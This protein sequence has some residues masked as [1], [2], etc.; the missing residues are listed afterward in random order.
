MPCTLGSATGD[1][2]QRVEAKQQTSEFAAAA[3]TALE[4]ITATIK[5]VELLD[6]PD[7]TT[8]RT[9][10]DWAERQASAMDLLLGATPPHQYMDDDLD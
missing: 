2:A 7:L 5:L 10:R 1:T 3:T 8:V 4:R 9:H 6:E